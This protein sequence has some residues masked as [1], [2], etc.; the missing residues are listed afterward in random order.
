MRKSRLIKLLCILMSVL[1]VSGLFGCKPRETYVFKSTEYDKSFDDSGR[2]NLVQNNSYG[3]GFTAA[4]NEST[5][6]FTDLADDGYSPYITQAALHYNKTQTS[7]PIWTIMQHHATYSLAQEEYC[8][9]AKRPIGKNKDGIDLLEYKWSTPGSVVTVIPSQRSIELTSLC[10]NEYSKDNNH[11]GIRD[12]VD[13]ME[14]PSGSKW[15]HLILT[16]TFLDPRSA[17][18][19]KVKLIDAEKIEFE[20]DFTLTKHDVYGV[21]DNSRA[22]QFSLYLQVYSS[23]SVDSTGGLT[24][25]FWLGL[26]LFD[27]RYS[28]NTYGTPREFS[29][30]KDSK[31]WM[32]TPRSQ[33]VIGNSGEALEIG[34][35][36][37]V[38]YDIISV[39]KKA[40]EDIQNA[41]ENPMFT[42]TTFEELTIS[43]FNIGWEM[44]NVA[45]ASI[46]M[47]DFGLW[48]T[49]AAKSET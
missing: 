1:V 12:G 7:T 37:H 38:K 31:A 26:R 17:G 14:R 49:P 15:V 35:E 45:D 39:A 42:H 22:A 8:E 46:K 29:Y 6:V 10:S 11:D 3:K 5:P 41:P 27:T 34:R 32:Y 43:D 36:Y 21:M 13:Y 18:A 23:N 40:L 48:M 20:V 19:S 28:F 47:K 16:S 25:F 9:P 2:V 44:T 24:N 33:D 30:D 4:N